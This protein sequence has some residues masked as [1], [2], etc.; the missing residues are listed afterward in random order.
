MRSFHSMNKLAIV[1]SL[2]VLFGVT[3]TTTVVTAQHCRDE[4]KQGGRVQVETSTL[5]VDVASALDSILIQLLDDS[6]TKSDHVAAHK[7]PA[8]VNWRIT[9]VAGDA[10]VQISMTPPKLVQPLVSEHQLRFGCNKNAPDWPES[11]QEVGY[12]NMKMIIDPTGGLF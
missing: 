8:S 5:D 10:P 4:W 9:E 11:G 1:P 12:V 7:G 6:T 2:L 3:T